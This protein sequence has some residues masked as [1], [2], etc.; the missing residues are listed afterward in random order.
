MIKTQKQLHKTIQKINR[1][2]FQLSRQ[3]NQ[4]R[5]ARTRTLIQLGGLVVKSG[6]TEK[7]GVE[8]GADLQREED[9]KKK[10]YTLL[11]LLISQ[12][13][14]PSSG[15]E[16]QNLEQIGKQFLFEKQND[17]EDKTL[18]KITNNLVTV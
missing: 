15:D 8:M 7:L 10:A 17:D 12:L 5:A 1:L 9:Q 11:G 2:Q 14:V 18:E 6:I 16:V 4:E 13:S 3:T